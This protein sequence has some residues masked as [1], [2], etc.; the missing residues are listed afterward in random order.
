M[1]TKHESLGSAHGR[2]G[3]RLISWASLSLYFGTALFVLRSTFLV[4]GFGR[5]PPASHELEAWHVVLTM[6]LW[7]PLSLGIA[8]LAA[9]I[10]LFIR[11]LAAATISA[12]LFVIALSGWPFAAPGDLPDVATSG[13][14]SSL[15]I[16][17]LTAIVMGGVLVLAAR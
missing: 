1:A 17:V 15:S 3:D 2:F 12:A 5:T 4:L 14:K 16:L 11:G 9:A 13:G 10:A 8:A 7:L 6:G